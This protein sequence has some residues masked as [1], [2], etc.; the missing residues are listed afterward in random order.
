MAVLTARMEL[1]RGAAGSLILKSF[2]LL[3]QFITGILL[4]RQLGAAG[5]GIFAFPM[6]VVGLLSI[7]ATAGLPQLVVRYIARYHALK[8]FSLMRGLI[9][10][11]NQFVFIF[12]ILIVIVAGS[13]YFALG[14]VPITSSRGLT[15]LFALSILPIIALKNV[16]MAVLH[17][18][19]KIT[20]GLLPDTVI[21]P[22]LFLLFVGLY[23]AFWQK[24][25]LPAVV[26]GFQ[27]VAA[28]IGLVVSG[29]LLSSALPSV[30]RRHAP[31]FESR[32]WLRSAIPFMFQGVVQ[33]INKQTDILM[34]GIMRPAEDVGVYAAVVQGSTLV[35]FILTSF[36]VALG[37]QIARL[38]QIQDHE[39]LQRMITISTRVIAAT[40]FIAAIVLIIG[41]RFFLSVFFGE[42]FGLGTTALRILCIGQIVNGFAGS[43]GYILNMTGHENRT[44]LGIGVAALSNILL[45]A[46]LVPK[47]GAV[48]AAIATT[49]SMS[50]WN[51]LLT[52]WVRRLT[53]IRPTAFG[54]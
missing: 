42:E 3:L 36:N 7:P 15:Y 24:T 17:G 48:G 21:K 22:V 53:G 41:G 11:S 5:Y 26:M 10:R 9:R 14:A 49:V 25:L 34:L 29:F 31:F 32:S 23:I 44:A 4:A 46:I 18:L 51:I 27:V 52:L 30:I 2:S 20:V 6:A 39:R 40:T 8:Q 50:L 37:P 43:N 45:N 33:V 54:I 19:R 12:S 16:K 47:F 35:T 38:W 28:S 1:P 13:V